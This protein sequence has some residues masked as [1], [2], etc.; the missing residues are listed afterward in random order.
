MTEESR[1]EKRV[2]G[3]EGRDRWVGR[4]PDPSYLPS[5]FPSAGR[6]ISCSGHSRGGEGRGEESTWNVGEGLLGSAEIKT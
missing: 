6:W 4:N 1:R 5:I 2:M 3:A